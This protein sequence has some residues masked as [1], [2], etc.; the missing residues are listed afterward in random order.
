MH[1][2]T[3]TRRVDLSTFNNDWYQPG[4]SAF[5]RLVWYFVNA[6]FFISPLN[7]ISGLKVWLLRAFGAKV[8]QGVIIKPG[9]NI[10][11]P[12]R[13]DIGDHVWIGER[14]WI[15]NLADVR[16]EA[17]VCLSQGAMLLTGNHDYRRSSFDLMIGE[18]TLRQ[19]CWIGAKTVVC[20]GVEVGA[21]AVL[22]VGSIANRNLAPD[23]IYRG[24]PAEVVRGRWNQRTGQGA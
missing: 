16:I 3:P 12:W 17:H 21:H 11:Y 7:P 8:G 14:V 22:S 15:D 13:L 10:K 19:G 1:E 24:N 9:V 23:Q 4:G 18:I 2:S 5:Q 6:L 20:P